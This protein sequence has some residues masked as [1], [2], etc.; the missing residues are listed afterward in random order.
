MNK[1]ILWSSILSILMITCVLADDRYTA[2]TYKLIVPPQPTQPT[3]KVVVEEIFWYGCPHCYDFEP[4]LEHWLETK[5][6]NIEFIRVPGMLGK[7]WI[8][9]AKAYYTAEI[10]GV[11]DKIHRPLFDAIHKEGEHIVNEVRL[12]KFFVDHGVDGEKFTETFNSEEVD[13]KIKEAFIKGKKYQIMGVPTIIVNGKYKT[14][15]S[16]AGSHENVI[17]TINE[18]AVRESKLQ[19]VQK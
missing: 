2:E 17:E 1:R 3:D 13:R 9:H 7:G 12:K 18:L 19:A 15:A 10:L 14:S 8:P 16:I 6:E 5:P 11:I 4:Y